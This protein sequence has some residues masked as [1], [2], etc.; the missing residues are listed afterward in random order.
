MKKAL[1]L[2]CLLAA[3]FIHLAGQVTIQLTFTAEVNGNHQTIDSVVIENLTQGVD[4][5]LYYPDTL[6][7][8]DHGTAVFYPQNNQN[9]GLI[10]YTS[11]PN[12]FTARTNMQF[13]LPE[14][15]K[16][17]IRVFD[18]S[19]RELAVYQQTLP[20][21]E[22]TFT[23]YSGGERYYLLVVETLSDRRVQKL[24]NLGGGS[25]F[26]IE[27]S[28][29][30]QDFSWYRYSK[31][32]FPWTPGDQLRFTGYA[33]FTGNVPVS[34]TITDNPMVSSL[35]TFHFVVATSPTYPPGFVHCD[36][37]NHTAI[38]DVVNHTT[39]RIWMDRNLGAAQTALDSTDSLA[40][41]DLYQWGRFADGHQCRN[42]S[43]NTTLSN[44]DQPGHDAFIL[45]PNTPNDWRSPQND[46]LWQGFNGVNNPCPTGYR[47][48]TEAELTVERQSWSSNNA[49]G[50]IASP[51]RLPM[52]GK[53]DI[54]T[55]TIL[56]VGYNGNYWSSTVTGTNSRHLLFFSTDAGMLGFY[57]AYG[58]S[59]RCIKDN[60]RT[61]DD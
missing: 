60:V 23:L 2:F 18:L 11:F 51:L 42:S 22:H 3:A 16:V 55:G 8:L 53:R 39:G 43:I 5:V 36:T 30:L 24:V 40:Y 31:S 32:G 52:A 29:T 6:L 37:A 57:R 19:G 7:E 20:E 17:T 1:L 15:D 59:V 47:L 49:A 28:K 46:N 45:A 9:E 14:P 33:T 27:H 41:G 10:L 61:D 34:D 38:V 54:S 12:P 56:D 21:G 13:F 58:Y 44:T 50:A 48:P 25:T 35:Y 26:R 4:I